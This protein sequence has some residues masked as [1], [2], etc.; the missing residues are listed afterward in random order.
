MFASFV[1]IAADNPASPA[2]ITTSLIPSS[3][4]RLGCLF[5]VLILRADYTSYTGLWRTAPLGVGGEGL[6]KSQM[7][8]LDAALAGMDS[9]LP[10]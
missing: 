4:C 1:A 3:G 5:S 6:L 8:S 2:P 9:L 7:P 10:S